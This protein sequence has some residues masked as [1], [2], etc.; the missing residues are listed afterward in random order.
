MSDAPVSSARLTEAETLITLGQHKEAHALCVAELADRSDN[1]HALYLLGVI[2]NEHGAYAKGAE[3]LKKALEAGDEP[4]TYAQL[5][6]A[7]SHL[8]RPI[9]AREAAEQ[10]LVYGASD[11]HTLD[12]IGV[13]LSRAGLHEQALEP[14]ARAVAETPDNASFQFNYAA[15]LQFSGRFAEADAAYRRAF[16]LDDTAFRALAA[17]PHLQKQTQEANLVDDLTQ[18][19]ART[20]DAT[21]RLHIGHALAKTFEDLGDYE[22]SL[23]WLIAAKEGVKHKAAAASSRDQALFAAA[24]RTIGPAAKSGGGDAIFVVGLPRTGTTLT[25]RILTSHPEIKPAGELGDFGM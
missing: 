14:F 23:H 21:H 17:I 19:F 10:A 6:R 5:A 2:A 18:A 15:S 16:A 20:A 11:A 1:P 25:E 12:T 9:E 24:A 8:H 13:V 4:R 3:L 7:L 22:Q